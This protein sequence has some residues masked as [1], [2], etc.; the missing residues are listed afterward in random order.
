MNS[1]TFRRL[2]RTAL[3]GGPVVALSLILGG[4]APTDEPAAEEN[5]SEPYTILYVAGQTGFLSENTTT[6]WAGSQAAAKAINDA[7]GIDGHPV[8][9][10]IIDDQSDSA[11]SVTL[12]QEYIAENDK[13]DLVITGLSSGESL[14]MAPLLSREQIIGTATA[15][16]ELLD[17]PETYPYFFSI[18]VTQSVITDAAADFLKKEGDVDKVALVITKDYMQQAVEPALAES[19]KSV[20]IELSVHTFDPEAIDVSPAWQ[21]AKDAGADWIYTDAVGTVVPRLF[22]GRVKA[23]AEDIPTIGGSGIGVSPGLESVPSAQLAGF[24]PILY[25]T[26]YVVDEADRTPAMQQFLDL[27]DLDEI[28]LNLSTAAYGWDVVQIFAEAVKQAGGVDDREALKDAYENLEMSG[29][30]PADQPWVLWRSL[31]SATEHFPQPSS[32]EF[33]L[34]EVT[35]ETKDRA[36]VLK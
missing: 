13:P 20:G 27:V 34:A 19:L 18:A 2:R 9:L 29:S 6:M 24:Y 35:G 14:A 1:S 10:K 3:V 5:G 26:S 21:S 12:L 22:D 23:G 17:D 30:D 8:E 31:Y 11:R 15:S 36:L 4:C 32:D 16:N 28:K 7:G 33:L 25:P